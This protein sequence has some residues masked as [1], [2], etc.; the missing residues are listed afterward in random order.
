[1]IYGTLDAVLSTN[2]SL[3][4]S[5]VYTLIYGT[6]NGLFGSTA[7]LTK[8]TQTSYAVAMST[9]GY[10]TSSLACEQ[11]VDITRYMQTPLVS[12]NTTIIYTNSN[13]TTTF[14][15]ANNWFK[16]GISQSIRVN[17]SGL[18]IDIANCGGG[19]P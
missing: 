1:L 9:N 11:N 17:T 5:K 19:I 15:G 6:L 13:L 14:N 16:Y 2:A 12:V 4:K 18:V 10:S 8:Q 7:N 3:T